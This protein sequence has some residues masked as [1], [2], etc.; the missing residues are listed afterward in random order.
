MYVSVAYV[1]CKLHA[2][3]RAGRT[4]EPCSSSAAVVSSGGVGKAVS[5]WESKFVSRK[6]PLTA[7]RGVQV[8]FS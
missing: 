1:G 6:T 8:L 7:G 3:N 4:E 5:R 2:V